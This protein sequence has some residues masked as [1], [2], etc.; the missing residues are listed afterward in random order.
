L[1]TWWSEQANDVYFQVRLLM[2]IALAA[3]QRLRPIFRAI[4]LY[5]GHAPI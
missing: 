1:A 5:M 2:T 4:L 3:K